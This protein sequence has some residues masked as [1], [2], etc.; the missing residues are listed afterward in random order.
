MTPRAPVVLIA[1]ASRGIGAAVARTLAAS[2]CDLMLSARSE[3]D[4]GHL[5]EELRPCGTRIGWAA[6]DATATG[7]S[8]ALVGQTVETHGRLDALVCSA[9]AL[10]VTRLVDASDDD[11]LASLALNL[12]LPM[13]LSRAAARVM[14]AQRSGR[15]VY[16]G[17]IFGTVSAPHYS[18]YSAAKAGI[19]GL[20]RSLALEF[21]ADNVQVNAVAPGQVRT[22]MIAPALERFGEERIARGIPS[23]RIAE[24]EEIASVVKFLLLDAPPAMTGSVLTVDGGFVCR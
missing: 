4:L 15:I 21:A 16:I 18:L 19:V 10:R 3:A 24:P 13:R 8:D 14:L 5:A 20:T 7:A 23:G 9:G 1:G 12:M 6:I 17:S 11:I 2:G 22:A